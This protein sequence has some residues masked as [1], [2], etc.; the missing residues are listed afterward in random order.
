MLH[1][2]EKNRLDAVYYYRHLEANKQRLEADLRNWV[3]A[4]NALTV[5]FSQYATGQRS[6]GLHAS[7]GSEGPSCTHDVATHD[8]ATQTCTSRHA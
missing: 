4:Y 1:A 7:Q 8:A 5:A 3:A 6:A 2:T